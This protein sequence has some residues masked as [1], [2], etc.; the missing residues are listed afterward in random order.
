MRAEI[1]EAA[2]E[3]R[4][5]S[6]IIIATESYLALTLVL[7]R[8]CPAP[9]SVLVPDLSPSPF[10]Q[11]FIKGPSPRQVAGTSTISTC[12]MIKSVF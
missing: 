9:A 3:S 2:V 7:P 5:V 10:M 4:S 8:N 12:R 6:T 11:Q 1:S